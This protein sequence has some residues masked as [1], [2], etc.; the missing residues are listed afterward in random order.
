MA[1]HLHKLSAIL[2]YVL[3]ASFFVAYLLYRNDIG[4]FGGWWL[5]VADLPLALAAVIYG[6]SSLYLSVTPKEKTS[7]TV[8]IVIGIPLTALFVW[9][10][11]LNFWEI[12]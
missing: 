4:T 9:L 8:A 11:V 2:F 10:V 1:T 5:N 6:G 12:L 3:G 7:K